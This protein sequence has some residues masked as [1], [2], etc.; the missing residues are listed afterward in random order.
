MTHHEYSPEYRAL[1]EELDIAIEMYG[2]TRAQH[3]NETAQFGD[4]WPGA[5]IELSEMA[6]D[7]AK[8]EARL[9]AHPDHPVPVA[10]RPAIYIETDA[11]MEV[12]F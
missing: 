2:E 7:I 9:K 12:P 5:Q 1:L 4:S 6:S 11:D 10:D 8:L 3:I